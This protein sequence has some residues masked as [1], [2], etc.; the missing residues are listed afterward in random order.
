M[1][2]RLRITPFST[3]LAEVLLAGF[4]LLS[5]VAFGAIPEDAEARARQSLRTYL[6]YGLGLPYAGSSIAVDSECNFFVG[7]R[8]FSDSMEFISQRSCYLVKFDPNGQILW[9]TLYPKAWDVYVTTGGRQDVCVVGYFANQIQVG[10]CS[11]TNHSKFGFGMFIAKHDGAGNVTWARQVELGDFAHPRGIAANSSGEFV[12]G[13]TF[14]GPLDINLAELS[15]GVPLTGARTNRILILKYSADG[16]LLWARSD[17]SGSGPSGVDGCGIDQGGNVFITGYFGG[18]SMIAGQELIEPVA[19]R[20]YGEM[21]LAKYDAA[22]QSVWI[23]REGGS[24]ASCG[25]R[26]A[27]DGAG[28]IHVA[29]RSFQG[30]TFAGLPLPLEQKHMTNLFKATYDPTGK[31]HSVRRFRFGDF[32][33][34]NVACIDL[35]KRN[36]LAPKLPLLSKLP[37]GTAT[38]AVTSGS[39][40]AGGTST[41]GLLPASDELVLH[42]AIS[43]GNLI[44]TWSKNY[45]H[46]QLEG[47]ETL[48]PFP[49]W[50]SVNQAPQAVGDE[51]MVQIPLDRAAG[52]YRLRKP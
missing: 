12:V 2:P 20:R 50:E 39:M 21:F 31:L 52:F 14:V 4:V 29:G 26:I 45:A 23:A 17:S 19:P 18:S 15:L 47:S 22:G 1:H 33:F 25:V 38:N 11:F 42:V 37:L 6:K 30:K 51:M 9:S 7:G 35:A 36:L 28:F 46:F 8:R 5:A 48:V 40:Q 27:I 41:A 49:V 10:S 13:V 44:L 16:R 43:G 32:D 24:P 3:C 34:S